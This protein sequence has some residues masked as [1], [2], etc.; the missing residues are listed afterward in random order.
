MKKLV[1]DEIVTSLADNIVAFTAV[2][3]IM[4]L[5]GRTIISSYRKDIETSHD[6]LKSHFDNEITPLKES[7]QRHERLL[8]KITDRSIRRYLDETKKDEN[9]NGN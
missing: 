3:T 5:I 7:N 1:L 9:N 8:D 6:D 4:V 2:L